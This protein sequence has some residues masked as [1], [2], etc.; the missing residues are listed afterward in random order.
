MTD[1]QLTPEAFGPAHHGVHIVE[2]EDGDQWFAHGHHSARRIA[3][4]MNHAIREMRPGEPS[5]LTLNDVRV[6]MRQAWG[7]NVQHDEDGVRW[8]TCDPGDPGAFPFTE[9]RL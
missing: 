5:G 2:N 1:T 4:A 8:D 7:N 9:V 6:G 3:A